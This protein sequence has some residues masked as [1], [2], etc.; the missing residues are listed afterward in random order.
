MATR[1]RGRPV[2]QSRPRF[3]WLSHY[4]PALVF[5]TIPLVSIANAYSALVPLPIEQPLRAVG[6]LALLTAVIAA[7]VYPLSGS[8]RT[9]G[10]ALSIAV[11]VSGAY[12]TLVDT[13]GIVPCTTADAAA[14]LL[15]MLGVAILLR[16]VARR[17]RPAFDSLDGLLAMLAIGVVAWAACVIAWRA[18]HA[19]GARGLQHPGG[20]VPTLQATRAVP[21]IVHIIFD[22]LGS[23]DLL[24]RDYQIDGPLMR[25]A[26]TRAGMRVAPSARANYT[27]TY[28]A[29]TSMLSME[30][31]DDAARVGRGGADRTILASQIDRSAV[32]KALKGRGYTFTLLSSGYEALISHP[33]ADVGIFGPTLFGEFEGN[34]FPR[35]MLRVLPVRSLTFE[36][37][38]RRTEAIIKALDDYQPGNRPSYVLAHVMVPHPPFLRS[39]TGASLTPPGIFTIKDGSMF[40]GAAEEYRRGYA[41]QARFTF[42]LLERWLN[43][44]R[45]LEHAPIVI[46]HGDHGPGLGYDFVDPLRGNVA[47]RLPIF[48]GVQ[49]SSYDL[50]PVGSP[51][52]IYRELFDVVFGA[53]LARLPDRSFVSGW[54]RPYDLVEVRPASE[55]TGR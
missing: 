5:S 1:L 51:V 16:A 6:L 13:I 18:V 48:L 10:V 47:D 52:N 41:A 30:Y 55:Q 2:S 19:N 54:T 29:V 32:I 23:L 17:S 34:L 40:P 33:L 26:L 15:F 39:E 7:C 36:P 44:W 35:S 24:D 45:T 3:G 21:D 8:H 38:R 12:P 22:G 20:T 28:L 25:A 53:R 49:P 31:L 50:T 42:R 37:H 14:G 27:Q 46:V 11:L 9:K 43:K 4:L